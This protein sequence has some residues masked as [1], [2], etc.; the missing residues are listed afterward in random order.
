[1]NF[2]TIFKAF[3]TVMALRDAARKFKA[4]SEPAATVDTTLS[5]QSA[6][7]GLAGQ[8]EARL[9]HV[10]VAA[11]KEAFDRDHARLELERSQLDEQRRRAEE[12]L[13]L[14]LWR[15]AVDRELGRLRLIAGA[16]LV[17]WIASIAM[18]AMRVADASAASRGAMAVGWFL[19]L[20]ALGSAF[21][22][23]G[24][25]ATVAAAGDGP[26]EPAR[27]GAVSLWLLVAGLAV[28]AISVLL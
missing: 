7:Q 4:G 8:I 16:G 20:A 19:L 21:T 12:A 24:R 23:Q 22:A 1:M 5:Q 2:V 25:V 15:Q 9:T 14:E 17:G 28:T 3:D 13:R 26:M 6:A 27:G 10:V 11:L 18:L